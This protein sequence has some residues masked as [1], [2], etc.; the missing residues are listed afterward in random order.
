M[1]I[2]HLL[3]A[4][5]AL[6]ELIAIKAG[7]LSPQTTYDLAV[8]LGEVEPHVAAAVKAQLAAAKSHGATEDESGNWSVPK[9]RIEEYVI[10]LDAVSVSGCPAPNE[11]VLKVLPV[12][13]D[14][15]KKLIRLSK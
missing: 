10:A 14:S 5:P 8:W 9:E 2:R 6:Q 3:D 11:D 7:A 13:L 1:T 15:M 4:I 12:S